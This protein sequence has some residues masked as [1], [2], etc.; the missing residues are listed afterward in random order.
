VWREIGPIGRVTVH[1]SGKGKRPARTVDSYLTRDGCGNEVPVEA[2]PSQAVLVSFERSRPATAVPAGRL[3][4]WTERSRVRG[5]VTERR[6]LG[7]KTVPIGH[8]VAHSSPHGRG[9]ARSMDS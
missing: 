7:S 9:L 8:V 5:A 2:E 6:E 3:N 4:R 1:R